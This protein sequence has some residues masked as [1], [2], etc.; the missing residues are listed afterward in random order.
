MGY[1]IPLFN[2]NFDEREAIA[3]ADTIKSGWIS[4]GPK[5]AELE[6]MFVNMFQVNYA[7]SVSNCTDALHLCCLVCGVGPGD[8][9][10][11]PSLT[12]AASANCIR[13]VGA[14][15]VFCDIV[16]PNHINI[17]P[18]DIK[19]K[20]TPKTKAIVVVHYAGM[21]CDMV[22]SLLRWMK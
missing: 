12:F 18:E 11:C 20:I 14:T 5:C 10:L 19:R 4:T 1:Q 6:Q 7:V 16:G 13:Y 8:E 15:P 2:L 9:V 21:V 22:D 3:A 17:D